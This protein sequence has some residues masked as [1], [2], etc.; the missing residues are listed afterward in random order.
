V[1]SSVS[2][3]LSSHFRC[4][5]SGRRDE[6]SLRSRATSRLGHAPCGVIS[7]R[8]RTSSKRIERWTRIFRGGG[9]LV[10]PESHSGFIRLH[11]SVRVYPA[12]SLS[13][14]ASCPAAQ[15]PR[16][17]ALLG[18]TEPGQLALV[19]RTRLGHLMR[20]ILSQRPLEGQQSQR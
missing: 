11:P 10:A 13:T 3:L 12:T 20:L 7:D 6:S 1:E 14:G 15:R 18:L 4:S 5:G 16:Y 19:G 2:S 9:E 17:P 8:L